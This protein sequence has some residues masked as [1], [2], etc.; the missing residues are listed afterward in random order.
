MNRQKLPD[1]W[2][3]V[4]LGEIFKFKEKTGIQA[5]EGLE[6]GKYKFFTSS[7]RQ[8][9]FLNKF[10][11]KGEHLIFST[12]GKAGLHYCNEPFSVSNDC[13]TVE[14]N[15][16][17]TKLISYLL[18]SKI[19]LLE[20]GFKGAGL[21]HL[22]KEYLKKIKVNLPFSNGKPNIKEQER[23]VRIL[24]K[25]ESLKQ[26]GKN[27]GDLLDEYL[28]SVFYEIFGDPIKNNKKWNQNNL[29]NVCSKI[30]DGEHATPPLTTKGIPYIS[31]KNIN[32]VIDFDDIKYINEETYK[33][34]TKRCLPEYGDIL[35]TC[36]GTIGR[37]KRIDLKDRFVFARSVALIKPKKLGINNIFLEKLLS[38][39]SM[40]K[41]MIG[42]T[43]EATV[44][45]L[46]LKQ[47]NKLNVIVPPLS[48]Q[49]KFAKIV[50]HVERLKENIKKT[51]QNSEE[52]FNSLIQ[53][54][55]RG[56]LV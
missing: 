25:A 41:Y 56:E 24:E 11:F 26:K 52:L 50:E 39:P 38:L 47:I 51:K 8:S 33:K 20:R 2:K 6:E 23:I 9:K 30:T 43:N 31:A 12:G 44:K 3:E 10:N 54:A 27:I 45:G 1:G 49:Q 42:N 40:K 37:I 5:G 32:E 7:D 53:K 29:G 15:G 22:S 13:F 14:V 16:H 48:L 21:K 19:Y 18:K 55:F 4:E 34:I 36:V 46:Y 17:S 28:K 35:I